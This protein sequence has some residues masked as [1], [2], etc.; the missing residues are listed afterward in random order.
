MIIN[1]IFAAPPIDKV[2]R[3]NQ[4]EVWSKSSGLSSGDDEEDY[5]DDDDEKNYNNKYLLDYSKIFW[6][7]S[8]LTAPDFPQSISWIKIKSD[9]CF[10]CFYQHSRYF[11][12][13][14]WSVQ[15]YGQFWQ[16]VAIKIFNQ[17]M[18]F[19]ETSIL[20]LF[21]PFSNFFSGRCGT[22]PGWS[23]QKLP[24]GRSIQ[25]CPWKGFHLST[26]D[27]FQKQFHN[28]PAFPSGSLER[29]WTTLRIC[30]GELGWDILNA[31]EKTFLCGMEEKILVFLLQPR[32]SMITNHT[33]ADI[34][35]TLQRPCTTQ[36]RGWGPPG[37][38]RSP[39]PSWGRGWGRSPLPW[40]GQWRWWWWWRWWCWCW[41]WCLPTQGWCWCR[42]PSGWLHPKL[43]RGNH[44]DGRHRSFGWI[45]LFLR[46]HR[47]IIIIIII[48]TLRSCLEFNL[49]GLWR[50][51][52]ARQ[53]LTDWTKSKQG[54][55]ESRLSQKWDANEKQYLLQK[56]DLQ[57]GSGLVQYEDPRPHGETGT[58]RKNIYQTCKSKSKL[59]LAKHLNPQPS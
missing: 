48:I 4:P 53:I 31:I 10:L 38:R 12:L 46:Y 24:T 8:N 20:Q 26:I 36:R 39:L 32:C 21:S 45:H 55:S 59:I 11:Q 18:Q 50:L 2:A 13:H 37:W 7:S 25:M 41:W 23:P 42:R 49:A 40:K 51:R 57:R 52:R 54:L 22:S 35:T 5:A 56:G 6:I 9:F 17:N 15:N 43:S 19:L 33:L 44:C 14:S 58:G 27:L 47:P 16:E 34:P 29:D 1:M 3:S 28:F 30:W